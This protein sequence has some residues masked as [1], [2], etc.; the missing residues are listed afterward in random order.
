KSISSNSTKEVAD[1]LVIDTFALDNTRV[2][3]LLEAFRI[4]RSAKC[5]CL[6]TEDSRNHFLHVTAVGSENHLRLRSNDFILHDGAEQLCFA[7]DIVA[8][9]DDRYDGAFGCFLQLVAEIA[10]RVLC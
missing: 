2:V 9:D 7:V 5:S 1:C 4:A 3:D 6:Q 10:K 8:V